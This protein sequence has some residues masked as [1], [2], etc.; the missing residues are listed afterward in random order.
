[1]AE[2]VGSTTAVTGA[3]HLP[4]ARAAAVSELAAAGTSLTLLRVETLCSSVTPHT[5]ALAKRL[6]SYGAASLFDE[7][8][9][10]ILWRSLRDVR[11]FAADTRPLW[12][13]S[14]APMQGSAVTEALAPLGAEWFYDWAGGL[15]WLTLPDAADAGASH[16][17][18]ATAKSKGYATLIRAPASVRAGVASF[19]PQSGALAELSR[20][21][22]TAFDP[23]GVLN[24]GRFFPLGPGL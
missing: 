17:R 8:Q 14:V 2:A 5:D 3:A 20:R 13:I 16:V 24:P 12:R 15:V 18:A 22:K 21:I 4:A 1:M 7:A 11:P 10:R 6:R 23:A 9:T 19:E